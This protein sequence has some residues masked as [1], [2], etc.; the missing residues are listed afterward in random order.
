VRGL[1]AKKLVI[2]ALVIIVLGAMYE[3]AGLS[4][5][6]A[7]AAGRQAPPPSRAPVTA[8]IRACPSP[9]SSSGG[10]VAIIAAAAGTGQAGPASAG[11]AV[12]SRLSAAGSPSAGPPLI[13]LTRPGVLTRAAIRVATAA[14]G[15]PSGSQ[16]AAGGK[17]IAGPSRGG[18]IVRAT[19]SMARALAVEQTGAGR[20]PTAVCN[21]P[22]TD[23]WFVGPG[24]HSLASIQLYLMNTDSQ[25]ADA[26]VDIYSDSGPLLGS[27]DTGIAVPAHGLLVQSLAKLVH[28]STVVALHVRTSVGRLVAALS[29]TTSAGQ[30]GAW[31]PASQ[32][33]ARSLVLPG[34]PASAGRRELYVAVP[35]AGNA[36]IKVTAVTAK[37]SYQP[38][39]GGGI[40]L[41][42]GSAVA[43]PLPSLAGAA[44]AVRITSNVPVTAAMLASG[45]PPGAP[46]AFTAASAPL[47]EQGVIADNLSGSGDTSTLILSAPRAAAQ[48][49]ITEEGAAA[50]QQPGPAGQ[51][52]RVISI[53]AKHTV[54]VRLRAPSGSAAHS[55]FAVV[56]TPLAGSG[57]VYAGRVL[58]RGGTVES[59]FP[60]LSSLTSVPLPPV[61][62][63]LATVLP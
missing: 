36:Q 16:S 38:T 47:E 48:V 7:L 62:D 37:G 18:V 22:G 31:L 24:Q 4:H 42:G 52:A 58:T 50:G 53:K 46:G 61:R 33:P 41:P 59:I 10:G 40:D 55:P 35:G 20:V 8:A 60:V 25:P 32:P 9:G 6:V 45:G 56:I 27:T 28:G 21:S 63:S 49:R 17:V 3:L 2:G 19:G 34:L 14:S 54:T 15:L 51:A 57:P 26:E 39:G 5:P 11:T 23:F 12:V 13:T 30:Q 44:A 1:F 29:E 43:V